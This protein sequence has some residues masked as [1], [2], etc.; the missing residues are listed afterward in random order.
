MRLSVVVGEPGYQEWCD[1]TAKGIQPRVY[2]DGIFI[3]AARSADEERGEVV[4]IML[5]AAGQAVVDWSSYAV[6]TETLRGRVR[7]DL[8]V[9]HEAVRGLG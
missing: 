4:A 1:L 5:D 2:V 3:K 6:M 8:P 9:V 7:I